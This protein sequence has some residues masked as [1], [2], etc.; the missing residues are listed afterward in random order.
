M[1]RSKNPRLL[2]PP[3]GNERIITKEQIICSEL[4]RAIRLFIDENDLVCAHL[5]AS[6]AAENLR[7]LAKKSGKRLLRDDFNEDRILPQRR[8]HIVDRL[9]ANF[10]KHTPNRADRV[11]DRYHPALTE[12]L[13][14]ECC[15][16]LEIIFG[17]TYFETKLYLAWFSMRHNDVLVHGTQYTEQLDMIMGML[18][19]VTSDNLHEATRELAE[20]FKLGAQVSLQTGLPVLA[21]QGVVLTPDGDS[22]RNP[23][24]R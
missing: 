10:F 13:L 1:T 18:G 21:Q 7:Q 17:A 2:A 4:S 11:W 14:F 9:N 19:N 16:D 20:I 12:Y 24:T 5:L 8:S 3:R 23:G 15:V 22:S 6:A